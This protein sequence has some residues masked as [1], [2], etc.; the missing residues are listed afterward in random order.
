MRSIICGARLQ[1]VPRSHA[2]R[3]TGRRYTAASF[4]STPCGA[5][6]MRIGAIDLP[7]RFFVAPMAGVTDRPFRQLCKRLGAG[8]AV[9]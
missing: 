4:L 6:I 5:A 8:Y 9:S 3:A 1:V 2:G 7:N